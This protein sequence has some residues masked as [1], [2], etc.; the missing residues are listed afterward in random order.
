MLG[1]R[2][3]L[4]RLERDVEAVE[5]FEARVDIGRIEKRCPPVAAGWIDLDH[6]QHALVGVVARD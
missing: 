3:V 4:G 2:R 6:N 1:D 5:L